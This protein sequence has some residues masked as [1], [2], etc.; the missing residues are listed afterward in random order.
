[1]RV[2]ELQVEIIEAQRRE[3]AEMN[4]LI[5]DIEDNGVAA[6]AA[7][8]ADRPVPGFEGTSVRVCPSGS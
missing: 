6:T 7:E 3:I 2:C 8:A 5:E 1:M 4:W